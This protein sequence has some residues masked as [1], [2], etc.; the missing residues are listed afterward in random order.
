MTQTGWKNPQV[1]KQDSSRKINNGH[2]CYPYSKLENIKKNDNSYAYI[3]TSGGINSTHKSPAVYCSNYNFNIPRN[4]TI[5]KVM[6]RVKAQQF[7]G[8]KLGGKSYSKHYLLKLKTGTSTTD[9]GV[10]NN[11]SSKSKLQYKKW[12]EETVSYTPTQWGVPK[13]NYSMINN[14]NFGCVH[15][16]IGT[17]SGW[18]GPKIAYIQMNIDYSIPEKITTTKPVLATKK[19][20]TNIQVTQDALTSLD[21]N[22]PNTPI[23]LKIIYTH[24]GQG[25]QTPL[26]T[27]ESKDLLISTKK[28]MKYTLPTLN[29][30]SSETTK[31]YTQELQIYPGTL[32]GTQQLNITQNGNYTNLTVNTTDKPPISF[33][34]KNSNTNTYTSITNAEKEKYADETQRCVITNSIFSNNKATVQGGA[35]FIQSEKFYNQ[36]NTFTNNSSPKCPNISRNNGCE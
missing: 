4:A 31:T 32:T 19:I 34:V 16:V 35:M 7:T 17:I 27:F 11:K 5:N 36:N 6:I 1:I 24:I 15:Q 22:K 2:A 30:P 14:N 9:Y 25:G 28:L 12:T 10:G 21:L 33:K 20:T 18:V 23:T 8:R 26:T 29:V 3:D 13:L